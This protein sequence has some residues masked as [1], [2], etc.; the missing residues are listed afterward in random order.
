M[1]QYIIYAVTALML[2]AS[3]DDY[4]DT[5]NERIV[6]AHDELTDL[7]ALRATTAALYAQPW[8]YFHKQRFISLGDARANNFYISNSTLGEVNA[9]ATL[10]EEKQNASIQYSWASLY[11]V[12]TQASY[13]INDYAPY[14][15]ENKVCS[16]TEANACIGEARFMRALAYWYLAMYWHDVPIVDDPTTVSPTAYANTFEDVIQYA[17]CEG[18]YA[19][20]WL[21]VTPSARGRVS[22][23]SA[24]ALLSRLYLTAA[25]WA[26]GNH[27]TADFQQ[28][29]LDNYYEKDIEYGAKYSLREFYNAKAALAARNTL[30]LAS[31]AGY[32][33][34]DNYEEIFRVQNNNCKEVLFAIQ[35]VPSSTSYGLGNELQG[36]FCY[37]R[38]INK[39]YG[40]TYFNWASYDMVLLSK[41]RGGLN[42]TRGNIMPHGM[43]YSYLFHEQDTCRTKGE[44]WTVN[45]N[46]WDP[47]A[48]KKQVVG[49]PL[50]TDNIAIQ[51]NSGFCTPMVRLSEVYLNLTEALMGLYGEEQTT[52]P[53]ILENINVVRRRA[54]MTEIGNDTYPG[55][56]TII[57]L[58]SVLLER[59]VEFFAE[60]LFWTDIVRRS[61]MGESHLKRM[62]DYQNNKLAEL[63]DNPLMG[64]HRL[65]KY[66]YKK[67]DDLTKIGTP[68]L[69]T[70]SN[71]GSYVII[72]PSRECVHQIPEGS[73]CHSQALGSSDNLWSMIYPPTEVMQ[74]AN[75]LKAP[76]SYD[77]NDIIANK[78]TYRYEEATNQ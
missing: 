45:R 62:I 12:I 49:G 27:F 69:S 70:N 56:Y 71:D 37:D 39:N 30:E 57:N 65:Y 20:K 8:Y 58:D 43:T 63:E 22:R 47:V 55:D 32:G 59:R 23:V 25:A 75:L 34:M 51:G 13:I 60:G 19:A 77:F 40:M 3:C 72:Q 50:G 61:F 6:P 67:D 53:K 26:T 68:T 66:S 52:N 35:T 21:P 24:W 16:E 29:V 17:I 4:L 11:N 14:C 7:N 46:S 36:M 9:Q 41:E 74:D 38:C 5:T 44:P 48:I 76:V 1:K 54:Y 18:E 42:R 28:R 78:Y 10:N 64:C 73:F 2:F 15:I 33:L 31:E